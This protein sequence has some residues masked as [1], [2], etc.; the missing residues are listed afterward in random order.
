MEYTYH[1]Y[2]ASLAEFQLIKV[3]FHLVPLKIIFSSSEVYLQM[4]QSKSSAISLLVRMV[5]AQD[6][7]WWWRRICGG[8]V[9]EESKLRLTQPSLARAWAELG[10]KEETKL[11]T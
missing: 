10:K 2:T 5:A 4:L 11:I 1:C 6:M 3:I 7:W 9:L 8:R